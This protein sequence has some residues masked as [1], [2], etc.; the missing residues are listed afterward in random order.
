M[1][2]IEPGLGMGVSVTVSDGQHEQRYQDLLGFSLQHRFLSSS[3]TMIAAARVPAVRAA[4]AVGMCK[5]A[6]FV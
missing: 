4:S 6:L 1:K 2:R 3:Y 5:F